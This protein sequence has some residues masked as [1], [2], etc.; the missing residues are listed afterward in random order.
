MGDACETVTETDSDNDGVVDA[1]DNC[2]NAANP[3]Q[4]DADSDG[5]GDACEENEGPGT[6]YYFHS[7]SGNNTLDQPEKLASFDSTFPTFGPDEFSS[8]RD[9]PQFQN[10]PLIEGVDPTW[11]GTL[12]HRVTSLSVD[13]WGQQTPAQELGTVHYTVRVHPAGA[14]EY[15]ELLPAITSADADPGVINIKHTFTQMRTTAAG[16]PVPLDLPQGALTFSI[17][18]TFTVNDASTEIR[19]DSTNYPSGFS[20]NGGGGGGGTSSPTPTP[21][22][23]STGSSSASPSASPSPSPTG[24][25]GGGRGTY[26]LTPNDPY[27][28]VNPTGPNDFR[29][30]QW[31]LRKVLAPQAWPKAT[32]HG[33]RVAVLDSGVDLQHE[34]LQ[35]P[36]K[37]EVATNSDMVAPG[38]TPDDEYSHG[39]H[40][41]GILGA[42]T[43]NGKG[44]AG[45]A[46]DVTIVPIRVLDSAGSGNDAQLIAGL[47]RAREL[48]VHVINMSLGYVPGKQIINNVA[49]INTAI[50][51]AR[52]AG[53][54][55]VAA[56]GNDSSPLCD[57]P[58]LAED[59]ICVGAT[60]S[61]DLKAAYSTFPNK[62]DA[63]DVIG[64][65]LVAPG[66]SASVFCDH[67][68]EYILS[69]IPLELDDDP[70][71]DVQGYGVNMGSSM[72]SPHVAGVAALLY[73][74][75]GGSISTAN[76]RK[77][78]DTIISTTRDLG[79]PGYDPVFGYG[80]ANAQAAVD[81]ISG[82][83]P[84]DGD[85][86]GIADAEDNCPDVANSGQED[87]DSDGEGDACESTGGEIIFEGEGRI[88]GSNPAT[89]NPSG[90]EVDG[91]TQAE[92]LFWCDG[93]APISQ[94]VDGYVFLLDEAITGE[95][96]ATLVGSESPIGHDLDMYFYAEDCTRLGAQN[97]EDTN[98]TASVP[99][100]TRWII[101][102][103]WIGLDTLATLT[104]TGEGGTGGTD[105][106]GDGVDDD[107]DNCPNVANPDQEDADEDGVG[108][109][110]DGPDGSV[111]FE[112]EG[113]IEG[114]D[115]VGVTRLDMEAGSTIGCG[116]PFT[117]GLD[118]FAFELPSLTTA[119]MEVTAVGSSFENTHDLDLFFY[120]ADCTRS[121]P[122][123][124]TTVA[125][126]EG[127]VPPGTK[128]ILAHAFS[129]IETDVLLTVLTR[130]ST[131]DADGDGVAD[132][133]D[134][135]PTVAN[136]GQQDADGDGLGDACDEATDSDGDGIGDED[137]NCPN[138]ANPGQEDSDGDGT[139]DACEG[140]DPG[141]TGT[142]DHVYFLGLAYDAEQREDFVEDIDNFESFL[143]TLRQN[144]CIPASQATIL[145][146]EDNFTDP[147]SGKTYRE[148]SEANLKAE[149]RRMGAAA[150]EHDDSQFF[151]F[152]SSHGLMWSGAIGGCPVDRVAGS[153]AD[154]KA[155]GGED[156]TLYDCELGDEL[157]RSFSPQTRMFVAVDCS[158]CGGFSDSLTA[159]SGTIPDGS[160]PTSSGIPA[161]NRV[162]VTGCAI[163]TECFGALD[164]GGSV[165]YKHMRKV[166]SDESACDGWTAPGF[167]TIQGFDIPVRGEPFKTLDGVCTA[168]EWFF[169][170]VN[171]AYSYVPRTNLNDVQDKAIGIQQQFRIKYGLPSLDDDIVITDDSVDPA[172][173][174]TV[175]FAADSE[176]SGQYTDETRIAATLIGEDDA[177]IED[178]ELAFE[179]T[180]AV[181]SAQWTA[182][183][184]ADGVASAT[185]TLDTQPGP[186]TLTVHY[187]GEEGVYE[188]SSS[189]TSYV[190]EKED[191]TTTLSI[192]QGSPRML[193]ARVTEGDADTG[194]AGQ[195]VEFT[196]DG[197]VI[198]TVSTDESGVATLT[199]S[200]PYD[201]GRHL[202][203]AATQGDDFFLGSSDEAET[204]EEV[205]Q[206]AFTD[207][208]DAGG[209]HS[210]TA[211]VEISLV[212]EA[213][214]PIA[215]EPVDF[216][217]S[218]PG[219]SRTW[220]DTTGDGGLAGRTITLTEQSGEHTLIARYGGRT[221]D[222]ASSVDTTTLVVD[223]ED[224]AL[225]LTV[226]GS[227]KATA[228]LVDGDSPADGVAGRTVEFLDNGQLLGTAVTNSDGVAS[229]D[230]VPGSGGRRELE[231]RFLGDGSF[232][233]ASDKYILMAYAL[234]AGGDLEVGGTGTSI[235]AVDPAADIHSNRKVKI[236]GNQS[237]VCGNISA[238]GTVENKGTQC[239]G[240][241]TK[242][243][244]S[245]VALPSMASHAPAT[246]AATHVL[247][248]DRKLNGYSCTLTGGCIVWVKG[249]LEIA[250]TIT[251]NVTFLTDKE[252]IITG[253]LRP[254]DNASSVKIHSKSN[255][256][257][258]QQG[259]QVEGTFLAAKEIKLGGSDQ[260]LKGL[261]WGLEKVDMGG[262][263]TR[264]T[265]AVISNGSL[266]VGGSNVT[267]T[268]NPNALGL[269]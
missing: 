8:A 148:G 123:L 248:G 47:N 54:V 119:G 214:A 101:A 84:P 129:G 240:Y 104:I 159:V 265:G 89:V 206:V 196:A 61:R 29:P 189:E 68:S 27:F 173:V 216:E 226:V 231:A 51:R 152:H 118:G 76:A 22:P 254:A 182:V 168:S 87:A 141:C 4:E 75:L 36:G 25:G 212:D 21:T 20:V 194:L 151:Y 213:G 144:Y 16:T 28:G 9:I 33:I 37:L 174:T 241:T 150:S 3:G 228:K 184:G 79:T 11:R 52:D 1:D 49:Q 55:L 10:T 211:R 165:M 186:Y 242:S 171:N 91:I 116:E 121:G 203:V 38:T 67:Y 133:E 185:R 268:Y 60:D 18:G 32:G 177:P 264:L 109:A 200:S 236:D 218:G 53:I 48:G 222:Y 142:P 97:T 66:G 139:G 188:P 42:C 130:D 205:T 90:E 112:G 237:R 143:A 172:L 69:T 81:S 225:T 235:V 17:R 169:A 86:D 106:D 239:A 210:D 145:A 179:L 24:G 39:T 80:L 134:N 223:K 233:G 5:Q 249:K 46:P 229:F 56:A 107:V 153:L 92:Y 13:F 102:N 103:A 176:E 158:F 163:T 30:T 83:T 250:G 70:C 175:S 85:G 35:C 72:A 251:G 74:R 243:G 94:G 259:A 227:R 244:A 197:Q 263:R 157:T 201:K 260:I 110:C 128:W 146:M 98:E 253:N 202:F 71:T 262:S 78:I 64:P 195:S 192:N 77:I 65:G 207:G 96:T 149:I 217:L 7:E 178:A 15:W 261:F 31:G 59:I 140:T 63:E 113:F 245:P 238:V 19:F 256:E 105:G 191:S 187:A 180:G 190:I 111:F 93:L 255:V 14:T 252:T 100:G 26:P 246:S 23:T 208:T 40:V 125:D 215:G 154:I 57:Y 131:D 126:E 12:R 267:I 155:G 220:T 209:Q 117:Q 156:G 73:D 198:G 204:G 115:P 136:P 45:V 247:T 127:P 62:T 132:D 6:P 99:A 135:C 258:T 41:A 167:P 161:P 50:E 147:A 82:Q 114:S 219:G 232:L 162:V 58:A 124:N 266:K 137:D 199:P 160:T 44:V 269:N 221:G 34:D 230:L 181:E 193:T 88:A 108:D 43:N 120:D 166:L 224:S 95:A 122:P 183:T 138:I 257:I 2:P 234:L 164:G 170:S